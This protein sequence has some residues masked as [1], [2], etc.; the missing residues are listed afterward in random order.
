MTGP[1]TVASRALLL[2]FLAAA[3]VLVGCT[4]GS[5]LAEVPP[6]ESSASPDTACP[7]VAAACDQPI[8]VEGAVFDPVCI[9]VPRF[10]LDVSLGARWG[11][12]KV[13]A[14][15]AVPAAHAVAVKS[16]EPDACGEWSLA[17]RTDLSPDVRVG[18]EQEVRDAESLPPDPAKPGDDPAG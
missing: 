8:E 11:G 18:I 1:S 5:E 13:R 3:M 9:P 4:S 17:V 15:A 6:H 12:A 16:P 7:V 10:L 14:I 2:S